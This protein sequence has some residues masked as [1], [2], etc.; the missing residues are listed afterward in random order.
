MTQEPT[1][2]CPSCGA[3][4][5]DPYEVAVCGACGADNTDD[6]ADAE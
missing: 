6:D 2:V 5:D 3:D 4:M 1:D